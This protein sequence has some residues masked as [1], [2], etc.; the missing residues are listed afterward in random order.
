M[1]RAAQ[2]T[3]R[4]DGVKDFWNIHEAEAAALAKGLVDTPAAWE[5]H[6]RR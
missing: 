6:L 5:A 2:Q 1:R 3:F 4:K